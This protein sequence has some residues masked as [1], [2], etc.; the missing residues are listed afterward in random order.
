[1]KLYFTSIPSTDT[2]AWGGI[3]YQLTM[4]D[5][6]I[7]LWKKAGIYDLLYEEETTCEE[8]IPK[9]TVAL[10]EMCIHYLNYRRIVKLPSR[11]DEA[12]DK[13]KIT[14]VQSGIIQGSFRDDFDELLREQAFRQAVAILAIV[15]EAAHVYSTSCFICREK[16]EA[17]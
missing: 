7:P 1:M 3:V 2:G 15:I 5:D 17:T 9:L 13:V 6:Y 8:A 11:V 14:D 12:L 4:S 16:E 10:L